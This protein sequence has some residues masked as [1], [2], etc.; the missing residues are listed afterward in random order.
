M[1]Y[2]IQSED[3]TH[4][5]RQLTKS[6]FSYYSARK[7]LTTVY[8]F[9][10][11]FNSIRR[12]KYKAQIFLLLLHFPPSIFLSPPLF[13]SKKRRTPFRLLTFFTYRNSTESPENDPFFCLCCEKMHR[14][15]EG[16]LCDRN[17]F[18]FSFICVSMFLLASPATRGSYAALDINNPEEVQLLTHNVSNQLKNFTA[19]F[20][21]KVTEQLGFCIEDV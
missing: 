15:K 20:G 17:A 7:R 3:W 14:Q 21:D 19:L 12:S 11:N 16:S 5:L 13:P 6:Y 18:V 9:F 10:R 1:I 4:K 2:I 8:I